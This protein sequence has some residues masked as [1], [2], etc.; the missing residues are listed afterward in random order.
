VYT[1]QLPDSDTTNQFKTNAITW[2]IQK[3][4]HLDMEQRLIREQKNQFFLFFKD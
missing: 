4:V 1:N 3:C 2:K